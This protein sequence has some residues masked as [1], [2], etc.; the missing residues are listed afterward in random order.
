MKN[1]VFLLLISLFTSSPAQTIKSKNLK[2]KYTPPAGWNA[3]E[4]GDKSPWETG[5]N[6][7]C[8]CSGAHFSKSHK[9]GKMHVVLYPSTQAGLDS[10]KRNGV[11]QLRFEDVVKF[12]RVRINGVSFERKKSNFTDTK[13]NAKSFEVYRYFAKVEDRFYIIFAWQENMQ[14]LNS[15]NEKEI[16]AMINAIELD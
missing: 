6:P 12:D 10:T 5:E 15:S 14:T 11:V 13:T 7:L 2:I 16:F 1:L 4:F 9:D 3:E 8:K